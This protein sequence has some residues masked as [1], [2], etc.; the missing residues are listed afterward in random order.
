MPEGLSSK[1]RDYYDRV[2]EFVEREILPIEES[3]F[4]YA[5]GANRWTP[6]RTIEALKVSKRLQILSNASFTRR[7]ETVETSV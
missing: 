5:R 4:E 6:N 2:K 1:A 7:L 3:L